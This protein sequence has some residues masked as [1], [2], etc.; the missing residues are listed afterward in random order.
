MNQQ[1]KVRNNYVALDRNI[2]IKVETATTDSVRYQGL[3]NRES[4]CKNCGMLFVWPDKTIRT[5]VMRN[6]RF[7]LDIIFIADDKIVK[8][9]SNLA[10]EGPNPK[11]IYES[12]V[13][14]NY[15]LEI[16]GGL[17]D[18]YGIEVG[19]EAFISITEK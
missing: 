18:L 8:I 16:N 10:P 4:L 9:D 11:E 13:P 12:S 1:L 15:V 14:V 7:P 6:M 5:F 2:K 17:S 19:D 3:S